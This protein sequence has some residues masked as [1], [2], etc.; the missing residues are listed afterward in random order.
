M[1]GPH[2][3]GAASGDGLR[4]PRLSPYGDTVAPGAER[5]TDREC[6][7]D[8]TGAGAGRAPGALQH[9]PPEPP[10]QRPSPPRPIATGG[11]ASRASCRPG[12]APS[13]RGGHPWSHGRSA[14]QTDGPG[15]PTP[16]RRGAICR[17]LVVTGALP[18]GSPGQGL[19]QKLTH[20]PLRRGAS[21]PGSQTVVWRR[22]YVC[23]PDHT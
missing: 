14:V 3:Y 18:R 5:R 11:C 15:P 6:K 4:L 19:S 2:L 23:Q 20:R 7:F 16:G 1:T 22:P 17:Y 21:P 12:P 8:A 13:P 10:A 9:P